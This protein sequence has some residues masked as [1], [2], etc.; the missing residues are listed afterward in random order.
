MATQC[1]FVHHAFC[2]SVL[3]TIRLPHDHRA[4]TVHKNPT[5]RYSDVAM[6]E[7]GELLWVLQGRDGRRLEC[8][9]DF[10]QGGVQVNIFSDGTK[11]MHR[12]FTTGTEALAWAE[13]EREAHAQDDQ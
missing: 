10:A 5:R 6:D 13:E 1:V 11:L 3:A 2:C 7:G 12:I 8:R 4:T 9:A